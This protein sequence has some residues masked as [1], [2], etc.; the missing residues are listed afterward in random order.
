M[1]EKTS[2]MT[3]NKKHALTTEKVT[4][5]LQ[6]KTATEVTKEKKTRFYETC[7]INSVPLINIG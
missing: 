1:V 2:R 4:F 5:L 6:T 7:M 3:T